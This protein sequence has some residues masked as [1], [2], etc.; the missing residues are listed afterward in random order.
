V[1]RCGLSAWA[2]SE[3]PNELTTG[4]A[5]AVGLQNIGRGV[6]HESES[7]PAPVGR[8]RNEFGAGAIS[9]ELQL[10]LP[11]DPPFPADRESEICAVRSVS[12]VDER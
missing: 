2:N 7:A 9:R 5:D 8:Y 1:I 4:S 3:V 10:C 6:W 12:R 11:Q